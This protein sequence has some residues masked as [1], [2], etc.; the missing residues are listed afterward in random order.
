MIVSFRRIDYVKITIFGF[1]TSAL[2]NSLHGIVLPLRL[3]DFVGESQ[4]NTYLGLLT[5]AGLILAILVQPVAGSMSDSS[6]FRWGRRRPYVLFGT[7]V[8]L[9]I[10]P[11]IGMAE[12]LVALF[13]AYCLLQISAN[14]AQG[15]YQA[16]IPDLVPAGKRG[17]ASGIKAL[18]EMLGGLALVRLIGYLMGKYSTGGETYWLW[19]VLGALGVVLLGAMLITVLTVKERP[20]DVHPHL[21]LLPTLRW[22][23]RIDVKAK[24]DFILFLVSRLLIIMALTTLQT[25]ALY[26]LRDVIGV[27]NPA[28]VT[29]DLL[30]IVG[31]GMLAAVYPAGRLTDKIGRRPVGVFAG[32]LGALGIV[33]FLLSTKYGHIMFGGAIIGVAT[34]AFMSSNWALATDL[35]SKGEEARYLGLTNLATAGGAALARLAGP[36]IDFF[37]RSSAGLGYQVMLGACF[38]YFIVGAILL[39]RIKVQPK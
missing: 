17:L 9:I 28:E 10:L 6:G 32:L 24:P 20:L 25:F 30:I 14:I 11:G 16:L 21:S 27:T 38:V 33:V 19:W 2:W 36:G 31:I 15:P 26:F 37:N 12:R 34:G 29:A 22:S 35:V 18:L 13:V 39:M 8:A 5:F 3:L 1:A 7:L 23:F 4:K